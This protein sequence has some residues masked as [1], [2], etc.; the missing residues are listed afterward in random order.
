MYENDNHRLKK[1]VSNKIQKQFRAM[2]WHLTSNRPLSYHYVCKT[3]KA[4][5]HQ[6]ILINI[7]FDHDMFPIWH[8]MGQWYWKSMVFTLWKCIIHHQFLNWHSHQVSSAV[9]R[10]NHRQ[11]HW[12][13]VVESNTKW[14]FRIRNT[15]NRPSIRNIFIH[16]KS[17]LPGLLIKGNCARIF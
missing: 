11:L 13:I 10:P 6:Q 7:F 2:V 12:Y 14:D 3:I 16:Y 1:N 17:Y 15:L 4:Y 9:K 5:F 8:N